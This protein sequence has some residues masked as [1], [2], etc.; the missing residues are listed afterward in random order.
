MAEDEPVR[1]AVEDQ[2]VIQAVVDIDQVRITDRRWISA[3]GQ[4]QTGGDAWQREQHTDH[5]RRPHGR[6]GIPGRIWSAGEMLSRRRCPRNRWGSPVSAADQ[7]RT[8]APAGQPRYPGCNPGP[9]PY[10]YVQGGRYPQKD[11][12]HPPTLTHHFPQRQQH[13]DIGQPFGFDAPYHPFACHVKMAVK[14]QEQSGGQDGHQRSRHQ[15][16]AQT[17]PSPSQRRPSYQPPDP[18][19]GWQ[20]Q[21]QGQPAE[22]PIEKQVGLA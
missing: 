4:H 12:Y 15:G 11:P 6:C 13:E 14:Q 2:V 20:W 9:P 10:Q 7:R 18:G 19:N 3:L 1:K 17:L 21:Q 16:V 22:S 5:D 8:L